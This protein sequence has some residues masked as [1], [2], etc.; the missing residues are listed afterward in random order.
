MPAQRVTFARAVR[1]LFDAEAT[2]RVCA[3]RSAV[4]V[5]GSWCS[6]WAGTKNT[7]FCLSHSNLPA[8]AQHHMRSP[9]RA[10]GWPC[11]SKDPKEQVVHH[12]HQ[13]SGLGASMAQHCMR[14]D[15][16]HAWQAA[17]LQPL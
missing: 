13:Q 5:K 12:Q 7:G 16:R 6:W 15:W 2:E 3:P 17:A 10:M 1:Q 4:L 14:E 9:F 8:Q 11:D